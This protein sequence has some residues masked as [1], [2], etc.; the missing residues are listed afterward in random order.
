[1][2][3]HQREHVLEIS[4]FLDASNFPFYP[5]PQRD[6]VVTL[7]RKIL[8]SSSLIRLSTLFDPTLLI[9]KTIIKL[10]HM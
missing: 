7:K 3:A 9:I 8:I 5:T 2:E 1:M 6:L 4:T 10:S